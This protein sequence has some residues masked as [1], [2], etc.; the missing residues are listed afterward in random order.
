[1][2]TSSLPSS[3]SRQ[4]P[5]PISREYLRPVATPAVLASADAGKLV[6]RLTVAVLMLFHGLSKVVEGPGQVMAMLTQHGLP[7]V[8]AYGAYLGEV[9]GP[10]LV[11]IGMYTRVGALLMVANILVA[12]ALVHMTQLFTLAPTG[13]WAVE[14]QVFYLFGSVAILLLGAG[15]FSL[16]GQHARWN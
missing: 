16:A 1:M 2:P 4:A 9:L 11:I 6:L 15:R 13:G 5:R 14:L 7:P 3:A 10:V 8:L 12:F